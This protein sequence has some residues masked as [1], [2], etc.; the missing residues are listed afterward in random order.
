MDG[1][2]EFYWKDGNKYIGYYKNDKKNGFGIYYWASANKIYIGFWYDGKQDGIG[3][4]ISG[5]KERYGYWKKGNK[6]KWYDSEKDAFSEL[7]VDQ[8][9][10]R[11]FLKMNILQVRDFLDK[12]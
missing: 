4:Y 7:K 8:R 1:Y 6:T 9:K 3:K 11:N 12:E 5:D 10:Y 2:G